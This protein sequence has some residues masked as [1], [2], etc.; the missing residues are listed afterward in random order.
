[1]SLHAAFKQ[2]DDVGIIWV[3]SEA[4]AT[5]VVHEF[6]ELFWLVTAEFI[7]GHL[8]L[9]L[10]NVSILLLLRST[11]ESLPW[12]LSFQ[13]I[14]KHVSNSLQVVSSRLLV[15]NMCVKTCVSGSSS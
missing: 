5:A 15:S 7:Y 1:V 10:F 3:L 6:F 2:I 4:E 8:L 13:E 11:R 12:K 14:E 9:L